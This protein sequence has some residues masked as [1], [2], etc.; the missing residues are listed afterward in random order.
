MDY[1]QILGVDRNATHD[2]IVK[3]YRQKALQHHPDKNPDNPDAAG[4][5][6]KCAEAFETLSD[7]HKKHRYDTKTRHKFKRPKSKKKYKGDDFLNDPNLGNCKHG[8]APMYDISG[9]KLTQAEREE[10]ERN[11]STEGAD[12][13]DPLQLRRNSGAKPKPKP[14]PK[15]KSKPFLDAFENE[16][17]DGE[18]PHLR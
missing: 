6:K 12:L 3:A 14:K 7:R 2:D 15:P 16:Y 8:T 4:E 11:A 17:L 9:K 18:S 10:W 5:F 13:T 1:Y